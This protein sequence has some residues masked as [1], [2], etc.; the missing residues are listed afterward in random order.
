MGSTLET[1]FLS[2]SPQTTLPSTN[3]LETAT[4]ELP[5]YQPNLDLRKE[6]DLIVHRQK[7]QLRLCLKH[8]SKQEISSGDVFNSQLSSLQEQ[9]VAFEKFTANF[10]SSISLPSNLTN[11]LTNEK[12]KSVFVTASSRV[13]S[14]ASEKLDEVKDFFKTQLDSSVQPV[15]PYNLYENC[16]HEFAFL[17]PLN[18]VLG[19]IEGV[20]HTA[21]DTTLGLTPNQMRASF[22]DN[23]IKDIKSSDNIEYHFPDYG[24]LLNC[25]AKSNEIELM[26]PKTELDFEMI[27]SFAE[28]KV[29][30]EII[31]RRVFM[32]I[33]NN[34]CSLENFRVKE[35]LYWHFVRELK[36]CAKQIITK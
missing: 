10:S 5:D 29:E 27:G 21:F 14:I 18:N 31:H 35:A 19:V 16:C 36:T 15:E 1:S 26:T 7:G 11:P 33:F 22:V 12:K 17:D 13:K 8:L 30:L 24:N 20:V 34:S 25:Y 9:K 4:L 3:L 23:V 32:K 2:F 28:A 6:K